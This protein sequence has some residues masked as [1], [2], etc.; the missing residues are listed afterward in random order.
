[1]WEIAIPLS[2]IIVYSR[3][4]PNFLRVHEGPIDKMGS[5]EP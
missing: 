5:S 4:N 3:R 1:M 2:P